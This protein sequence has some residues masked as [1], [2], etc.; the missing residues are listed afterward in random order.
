MQQAAAAANKK[1]VQR[2]SNSA[3]TQGN[4][5]PNPLVPDYLKLNPIP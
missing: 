3:N 4:A 1:A 2:P 5:A